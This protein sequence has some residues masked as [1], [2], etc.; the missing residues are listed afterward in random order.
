MCV[1]MRGFFFRWGRVLWVQRR[2]EAGLRVTDIVR[3]GESEMCMRW[4]AAEN[5][6]KKNVFLSFIS[7][8]YLKKFV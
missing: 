4:R 1:C 2:F 8:V 5:L 7:I 3:N 6:K